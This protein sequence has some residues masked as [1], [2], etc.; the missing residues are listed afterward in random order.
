M[1]PA[2]LDPVHPRFRQILIHLKKPASGNAWNDEHLW[3]KQGIVYLHAALKHLPALAVIPPLF[4]SQLGH[5]NALRD[6]KPAPQGAVL[7]QGYFI[8]ASC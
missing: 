8:H 3:R 6:E 1:S 2:L 7:V 4:S 5:K